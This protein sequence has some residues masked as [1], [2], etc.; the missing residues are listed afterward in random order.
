MV[1]DDLLP[2]LKC[3]CKMNFN[4]CSQHYFT[5]LSVLYF[6]CECVYDCTQTSVISSLARFCLGC[7]S[8][9]AYINSFLEN[10][11]ETMVNKNK[12][13]D[14]V[15]QISKETD[16]HTKTE[17]DSPVNKIRQNRHSKM[18]TL[19]SSSIPSESS[20]QTHNHPSPAVC[21][22]G[23]CCYTGATGCL[24]GPLLSYHLA[25]SLH[26][27]KDNVRSFEMSFRN[28]NWNENKMQKLSLPHTRYTRQT[29]SHDAYRAQRGR[30][31]LSCVVS[32]FV[33]LSLPRLISP[34]N[35]QNKTFQ[36]KCRQR[37]QECIYILFE[38]HSRTTT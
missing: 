31:V 1:K 25:P 7:S 18:R 29:K 19:A 23:C 32:L 16:K 6:S 13:K 22:A 5:L 28:Y 14:V 34:P 2:L 37:T 33:S 8:S 36:A 27:P 26:L 20:L 17:K 21:A 9:G 15:R 4:S 35:G 24:A 10:K 12:A 30:R 38:D 3:K 11:S